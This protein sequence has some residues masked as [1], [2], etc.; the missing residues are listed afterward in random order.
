MALSGVLWQLD[1]RTGAVR[2]FISKDGVVLDHL[3]MF[4]VFR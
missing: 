1:D 4:W 3:R 2:D